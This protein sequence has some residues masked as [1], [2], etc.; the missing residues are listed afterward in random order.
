M[1][2][3]VGVALCAL[4]DF[5]RPHFVL[6]VQGKRS[7]ALLI[8]NSPEPPRGSARSSR[9]LFGIRFVC[10]AVSCCDALES[11]VSGLIAFERVSNEPGEGKSLDSAPAWAKI[12]AP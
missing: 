11:W 4:K 8:R 3:P 7:P 5:K 9:G 6:L 1:P 2:P 12:P 10:M